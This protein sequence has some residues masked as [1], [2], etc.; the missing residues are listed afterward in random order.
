MRARAAAIGGEIDETMMPSLLHKR[1]E[2]G[3]KKGKEGE[4]KGAKYFWRTG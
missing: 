3:G 1:S 2:G 4:T